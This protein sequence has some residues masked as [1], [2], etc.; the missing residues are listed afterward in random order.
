MANKPTASAGFDPAKIDPNAE[1]DVRITQPLQYGAAHL[2][3]LHDHTMT[4]AFLALLVKEF[5]AGVIYD[6][7]LRN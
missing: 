3:P 7:S 4:G 5:G 2:L 6:A 1:Y